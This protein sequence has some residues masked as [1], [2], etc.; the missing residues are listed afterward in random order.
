MGEKRSN[1]WPVFLLLILVFALAGTTTYLLW[2]KFKTDPSVSTKAP[3]TIGDVK[4]ISTYDLV[5]QRRAEIHLRTVDSIYYAISE[6]AFIEIIDFLGSTHDVTREAVVN[7]FIKMKPYY[8]GISQGVR[9]QE[10]LQPN[11]L[12]D[13]PTVPQPIYSDSVRR[14]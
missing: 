11:L 10:R 5:K 2:N 8:L 12:N 13:K 14:K 3:P 9:R 1:F 7:Q 4:Y 6:P